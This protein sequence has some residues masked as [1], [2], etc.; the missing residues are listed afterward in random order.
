MQKSILVA[1]ILL[2]VAMALSFAHTHGEGSWINQQKLVDPESKEW[3]CN[4]IDCRPE[5]VKPVDGGY[6]VE[7]GEVIPAHR[8]LWKSPDGRWWRCRYM[9]WAT[10]KLT[11]CLIGPPPGS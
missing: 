2:L 1:A 9:S 8:V 10:G 5:E 4:E 7:T 11:R 3:C 6:L